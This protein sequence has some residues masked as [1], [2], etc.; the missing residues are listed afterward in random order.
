ML[1]YQGMPRHKLLRKNTGIGVSFSPEDLDWLK[2]TYGKRHT[3]T[4]LVRCAIHEAKCWRSGAPHP[5][6]P[7]IPE[8]P[9]TY[10]GIPLNPKPMLGTEDWRDHV[11][12]CDIPE[13]D[14]KPHDL[15]PGCTQTSL[16]D[17]V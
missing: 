2:S 16:T 15:P 1:Q 17:P 5:I 4:D 3:I 7:P 6:P 10:C 13:D 11:R 14:P 9:Q 8:P 12:V